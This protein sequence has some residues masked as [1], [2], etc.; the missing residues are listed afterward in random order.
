MNFS[1]QEELVVLE[2]VEQSAATLLEL[3]QLQLVVVAGGCG[4][5]IFG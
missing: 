1:T 3:S 5:V 4:E 2:A